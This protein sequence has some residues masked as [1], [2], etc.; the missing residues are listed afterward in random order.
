MPTIT[1][2]LSDETYNR[3]AERAKREQTTV[4]AVVLPALD[5]IAT[6]SPSTKVPNTWVQ[7][8]DRL[9]DAIHAYPPRYPE[10]HFVD[11]SRESIYEG[12]GE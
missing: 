3:L 12:R 2:N 11:D 10:G 9:V 4:E 1:L 6:E 7:S 8:F 5:H